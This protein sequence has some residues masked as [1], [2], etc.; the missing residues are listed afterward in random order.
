[1][2][3]KSEGRPAVPIHALF[4]ET[5]LRP[6][7]V[8]DPRPALHSAEVVVGVDVMSGNQFLVY[9]REAL[10]KAARGGSKKGLRVLRVELDQETQELE[11]LCALVH[12]VKGR[13]EYRPE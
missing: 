7:S 10:S 5:G 1:V 4:D 6:N 12:V 2:T 11:L 3:G 13:H 8:A 9:G